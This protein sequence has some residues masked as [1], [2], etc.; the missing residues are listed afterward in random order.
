MLVIANINPF[1]VTDSLIGSRDISIASMFKSLLRSRAL[2]KELSG[3]LIQKTLVST[4]TDVQDFIQ[5][6]SFTSESLQC[7]LTHGV[8][9]GDNVYISIQRDSSLIP[10]LASSSPFKLLIITSNEHLIS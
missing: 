5:S 4:N 8:G 2:E 6:R 10:L 3:D 1:L 9:A 7:L